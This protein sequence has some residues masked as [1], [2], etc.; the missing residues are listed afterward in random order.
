MAVPS[1]A[2]ILRGAPLKT[3]VILG[4]SPSSDPTFDVEFA[5]ATSSGVYATVARLSP[6]GAGIPVSYT[7]LLPD[8]NAIRLYKARAVKDGWDPGDYTSAVSA[9]PIILPEVSPN[10]TPLTGKGIGSPLFISTGA[11]PTVGQAAAA[12][13]VR[14]Y[15][16]FPFSAVVTNSAGSTE[17]FYYDTGLSEP[18]A[19]VAN[20]PGTAN[21]VLAGVLPP[22]VTIRSLA[23][24]A[25]IGT[26]TPAASTAGDNIQ[27]RVRLGQTDL[28]GGSTFALLEVTSTFGLG[29]QQDTLSGLS[30]SASTDNMLYADLTVRTINPTAGN[31]GG[32]VA[33]TVGY[34]MPSYDK[35]V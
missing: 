10:I 35:A 18:I 29:G 32:F 19:Y 4:V 34:D 17:T 33:L 31:R 15:L 11:P 2:R 7:D 16:V 20:A 22:G 5:R 12:A 26:T 24:S 1:N 9:K 13:N 8:D 30:V 23:L 21:G 14:K 25:K 3:G 27:A 28:G 6:K